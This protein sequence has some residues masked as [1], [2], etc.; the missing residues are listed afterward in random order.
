MDTENQAIKAAKEKGIKYQPYLLE[1]EDTLLQLLARFRYIIAKKPN[2]WTDNQKKRAILLFAQYPLL[3][4]AYNHILWLRN[5]YTNKC[6]EAARIEF[7]KWLEKTKTLD[8]K[9]FNTVANTIE[10]KMETILNYF[11]N[12]NTNANAEYFNPSCRLT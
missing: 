12:R 10:A 8:I 5:I 1:N 9:E 6:K 4:Q 2:D 11:V 7:I 3:E